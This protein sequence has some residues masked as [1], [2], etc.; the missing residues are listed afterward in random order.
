[1]SVLGGRQLIA[2]A[3]VCDIAG[4]VLLLSAIQEMSSYSYL[5]NSERRMG[6]PKE[7]LGRLHQIARLARRLRLLAE[8]EPFIFMALIS[9]EQ[10][11]PGA[12]QEARQTFADTLRRVE[13]TATKQAENFDF[14]RRMREWHGPEKSR[15]TGKSAERRFIWERTFELWTALGR[16]V[17]YS[18]DGPVLRFIRIIHEALGIPAPK[19]SA[20]RQAIDDFNGRPR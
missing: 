9:A 13:T 10:H 4:H 11:F 6:S 1:M 8:N 12:A 16:R 15:A 2:T 19:P 20:V 14:M 17:G 3:G 7:H 5:K 18:D